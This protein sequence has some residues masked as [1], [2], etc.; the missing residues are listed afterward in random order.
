MTADAI[1]M[2]RDQVAGLLSQLDTAV[3]PR[4]DSVTSPGERHPGAQWLP[5]KYWMVRTLDNDLADPPCVFVT[6]P[7]HYDGDFDAIDTAGARRLAMALLAAADR[8]D[9]LAAGV[10]HLDNHR[11]K[12]TGS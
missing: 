4:P 7:Q 2:L 8:A 3:K 9:E 10:P 12:E 11:T 5:A 1:T 6:T